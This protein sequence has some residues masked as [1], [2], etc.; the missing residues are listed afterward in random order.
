MLAIVKQGRWLT[1]VDPRFSTGSQHFFLSSL[2][3][4]KKL[5]ELLIINCVFKQN[6][7]QDLSFA[8]I[9]SL[10]YGGDSH[11]FCFVFGFSFLAFLFSLSGLIVGVVLNRS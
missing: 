5:E 9:V 7:L 1:S 3:C 8:V 11:R 4:A 2:V 10:C 6:L